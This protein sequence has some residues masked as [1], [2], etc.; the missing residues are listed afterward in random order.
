M[1][2]QD[3]GQTVKGRTK[4]L[5]LTALLIALSVL[6]LLLASYL[7]SGRM[8]IVAVAGLLPAAAVISAGLRAGIFCYIG[9]G[10]A[11]HCVVRPLSRIEKFN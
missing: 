9:T 8:G 7:P 11:V 4:K 2:K 10:I 6:I 3:Y 5:T 1:A